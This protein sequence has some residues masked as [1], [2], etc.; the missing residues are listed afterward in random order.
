MY[1]YIVISSTSVEDY[2]YLFIVL[3]IVVYVFMLYCAIWSYDHKI[4]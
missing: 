3:S 1:Y 2:V 4:E